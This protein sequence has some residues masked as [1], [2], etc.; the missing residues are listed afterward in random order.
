MVKK[1]LIYVR[2]DFGKHIKEVIGY[3]LR[4]CL[5]TMKMN[6]IDEVKGWRFWWFT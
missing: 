3:N 2:V 6:K 5:G 1:N 4:P